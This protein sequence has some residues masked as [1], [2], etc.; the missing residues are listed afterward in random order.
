MKYNMGD[1]VW[2][3][4]ANK[5]VT[6][7]N[8]KNHLF[9]IIDNDGNLVPMDYYGF[10]ISSRLEKSKNNSKYKYNEEI[11]NDNNN[12]LKTKSIVKCDQLMNIPSQNIEMKIG[13]VNESDLIRF[14]NAFEN[15]MGEN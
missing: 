12:N 3:S 9:V 8:V 11:E 4:E 5:E 6:N 14:L 13:E 1:I 2:V 10:V 15:S 7:N